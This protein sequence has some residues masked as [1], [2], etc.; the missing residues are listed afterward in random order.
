MDL[1]EP[2]QR[3]VLRGLEPSSCVAGLREL[4]LGSLV[5]RRFMAALQYLKGGVKERWRQHSA[6]PVAAE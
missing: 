4:Q 6:G 2:V 3:K 1:L 5:K